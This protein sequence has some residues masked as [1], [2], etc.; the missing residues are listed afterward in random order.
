VQT[1]TESG[2]L[3]DLI[4]TMTGARICY[5]EFGKAEG[6]TTDPS[7]SLRS[8]RDDK[9]GVGRFHRNRMLV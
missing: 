7:T 4:V 8:G 2:R 9:R 3:I 6:R 1:V 5:E